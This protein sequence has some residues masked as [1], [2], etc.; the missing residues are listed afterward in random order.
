MTQESVSRKLLPSIIAVVY[1]LRTLHVTVRTQTFNDRFWQA[2]SSV[3]AAISINCA[4]GRSE[5]PHFV[6]AP[7]DSNYVTAE[8]L[9]TW[10]GLHKELR[11]A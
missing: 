8:T 3:N 11:N 2:I 5:P 7:P 9:S 6:I 4:V 1:A 10:G